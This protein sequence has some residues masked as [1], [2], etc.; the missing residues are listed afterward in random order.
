MRVGVLAAAAA[1]GVAAPAGAAEWSAPADAGPAP[2]VTPQI[3]GGTAVRVSSVPWQARVRMRVDGKPFDDP[4]PARGKGC[5]A[6]VLNATTVVTAMHCVTDRRRPVPGRSMRV[7]TGMSR[8]STDPARRE[9]PQPVEG[10]TPQTVGVTLVRRHPGWPNPVPGPATPEQ[11]ADDVATLR[12]SK[13]L[14]FDANTKPVAVADPGQAP[15]GGPALERRGGKLRRGRLCWTTSTLRRRTLGRFE[16]R[17][18]SNAKR[19]R[20]T[21]AKVTAS[22]SGVGTVKANRKVTVRR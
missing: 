3:T 5:G 17:A 14:R 19:G 8:Y 10:D 18:R 11:L 12:L 13:P 16:L 22:A 2:V 20:V 15:S 21:V 1:A 4:S 9:A 6:V 7:D